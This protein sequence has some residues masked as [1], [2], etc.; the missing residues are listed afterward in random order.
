MAII[1]RKEAAAL[2]RRQ[3]SVEN[4]KCEDI[5]AWHYGRIELRELLDAIYGPPQNEDEKIPRGILWSGRMKTR[6]KKTAMIQT[7]EKPGMS[8]FVVFGEVD[9]KP[10]HWTAG[11]NYRMDGKS[12]DL[13]LV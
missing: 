4:D 2:V 9:G 3:L 13:D 10:C 1:S 6:D 12:H 8:V 11:G 7:R 5:G